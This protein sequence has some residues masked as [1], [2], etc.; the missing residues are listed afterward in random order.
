MKQ[1]SSLLFSALFIVLVMV[2]CS[3]SNSYAAKSAKEKALIA[4]FIKRNNINVLSVAPNDS[5]WKSNDY[6][7]TASGLYYHQVS[8]GSVFDTAVIK[9][10]S[11]FWPRYIES[12]LDN[13]QQVVVSHWTVTD[14]PYPL[15]FQL[16]TDTLKMLAFHETVRRMKHNDAEAIIIVPSKIGF[17]SNM[18]YCIP[19]QYRIKLKFAQSNKIYKFTN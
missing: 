6:L 8:A 9:Q 15:S 5:S 7:L 16:G 18:A 13:P 2:S 14:D 1:F 4:D 11:I 12:T 19:Y 17:Q 10:N 3:D